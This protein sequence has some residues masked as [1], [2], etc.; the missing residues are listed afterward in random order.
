MVA[1][2]RWTRAL[3]CAHC[4]NEGTAALAQSDISFDVTAESISTG[5]EPVQGKYGINFRCVPCG[6]PLGK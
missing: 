4:W 2:H 3:R 6:I 5:F 1:I